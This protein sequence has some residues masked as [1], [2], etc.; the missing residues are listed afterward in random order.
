MAPRNKIF[1]SY[2]HKDRELFA[3]FKTMMAPAIE[4][5]IVDLW[6]DQRIPPGARWEQEIESALSSARIAVLLV[7]PDFLAAHFIVKKELHPLL[8]AARQDGVTIFWIYLRSCLLN[9][10]RSPPIR[11]RTMFRGH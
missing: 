10:R 5:N 8:R 6:D 11:R 4:Q 7:S 9:T 2:S 3:E 1:V